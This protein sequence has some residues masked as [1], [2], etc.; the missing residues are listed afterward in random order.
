MTLLILYIKQNIKFM[1]SFLIGALMYLAMIIYIYPTIAKMDYI[2]GM[3]KKMP[4]ELIAIFNINTGLSNINSFVAMEYY[5]MIF[6][7]LMFCFSIM[8]ANNLYGKWVNNQ[9][10]AVL[11]NL[12]ISRAA[13]MAMIQSVI[14]AFHI[15][16]G[17]L[18]AAGGMLLIR[19]LA[20][21]TDYNK[22]DFIQ[23]NMLGVLLFLVLSLFTLTCMLLTDVKTGLSIGIAISFVMYALSIVSKLSKDTEWLKHLTLFTLNDSAKVS[24]GDQNLMISYSVYVVI[25]AILYVTNVFLFKRKNLYL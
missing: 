23:L 19:I 2:D 14:V 20:G 4:K 10:M 21:S 9:S 11:L 7:I 5:G 6:I 17:G 15:I 18:M 22:Y 8:L 13:L 16:L 24:V 25:A 3:I 1:L 12:P